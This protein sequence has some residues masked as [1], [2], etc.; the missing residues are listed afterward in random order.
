MY[1]SIDFSESE[2]NSKS[3]FAPNSNQTVHPN[4]K[5]SQQINQKESAILIGNRKVS[6]HLGAKL[7]HYLSNERINSTDKKKRHR[8][9]IKKSDSI[10]STE[11]LIVKDEA[12][13]SSN[14]LELIESL[15]VE[16][17]INKIQNEKKKLVFGVPLTSIMQSSGQPLP[18]PILES[19]RFIRKIAATEVGVFRK[20][21]N[22]SRIKKLKE[23]ID[24]NEAI[25]FVSSD[26]SVFDVAD[27]LK[28]YFRE[29]PECLITNKLSDILLANYSSKKS[30]TIDICLRFKF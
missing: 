23:S 9:S 8:N 3:K 12:S 10:F 1:D 30:Y 26:L 18:Q 22:K 14:Q 21:G 2:K 13:V 15:I 4:S 24:N 20:N 29:L 16:N 28:L 17:S 6:T 19:M 11:P 27:T 25:N 7:G 5:I